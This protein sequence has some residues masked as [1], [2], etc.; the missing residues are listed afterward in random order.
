MVNFIKTAKA[1]EITKILDGA[2]CTNE[3][4][5][6]KTCNNYELYTGHALCTDFRNL[7]GLNIIN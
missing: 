5:L 2:N 7:D 6:I 1:N 3:C 4:P